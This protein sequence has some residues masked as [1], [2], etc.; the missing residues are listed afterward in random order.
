MSVITPEYESSFLDDL[1]YVGKPAEQLMGLAAVVEDTDPDWRPPVSEL[2]KL[3][4]PSPESNALLVAGTAYA[5]AK[6][7]KDQFPGPAILLFGAALNAIGSAPQTELLGHIHTG[8]QALEEHGLEGRADISSILRAAEERSSFDRVTAMLKEEFRL[9]LED[10]RTLQDSDIEPIV[11]EIVEATHD[12]RHKGIV[13]RIQWQ[14]AVTRGRG[15]DTDAGYLLQLGY[16]EFTDQPL[17]DLVSHAQVGCAHSILR[18]LRERRAN[19]SSF[20]A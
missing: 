10:S 15:T 13:N 8:R 11:K 4:S 7:L 2:V 1:H 12:V 18:R 6:Q 19:A 3:L 16:I 5:A 17:R 14:N 9:G 20:G